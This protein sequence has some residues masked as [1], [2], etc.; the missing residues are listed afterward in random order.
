MHR[1]YIVGDHVTLPEEQRSDRLWR[2]RR[3]E[4]APHALNEI[5]RAPDEFPAGHVFGL[6]A[7]NG[8]KLCSERSKSG[9]SRA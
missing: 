8:M 6:Y 4:M 7:E 1:D 9:Y 5:G 2:F 3:K